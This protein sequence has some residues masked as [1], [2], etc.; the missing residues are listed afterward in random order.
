[1]TKEIDSL[2]DHKWVYTTHSVPFDQKPYK[3]EVC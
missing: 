2:C 3:C 1:M